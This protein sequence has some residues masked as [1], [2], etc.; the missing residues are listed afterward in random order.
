L[1]SLTR[2]HLT[3]VY[4]VIAMLGVS[5]AVLAAP[6]SGSTVTSTVLPNG[7]KVIVLEDHSADLVAVEVWVRAGNISEKK[8]NNGVAHFIEHLLFKGTVKR[9]SGQ[10]DRD[11]ESLGATLDASTTRDS[12]R[13]STV[14]ASKYFDTALD[15]IS[16][17]TMR[18]KFDPEDVQRE[19]SVILDE[20]SRRDAD[21][22]K[23]LADMMA[24]MSFPN[25]PYGFPVQGSASNVTAITVEQIREFY[26]TYF[27]PN[28]MA[29]VIVGDMKAAK[30]IEDVSAAF[31]DFKKKDLPAPQI[32]APEPAQARKEKLARGTKLTYYAIGFPAPSIREPADV[33]AMD[34]LV[35]YLA[36]GYR[37]WLESIQV[38]KGGLQMVSGEYT[39]R[40]DPSNMMLMFATDPS[41]VEQ[42]RQAI[43]NKVKALRETSLSDAEVAIAERSIEGSIAFDSETFAGR[44]HNLGFYE[45]LGDYRYA[46]SYIDEIR[47][48][49][50]DQIRRLALKYL[51]TDTCV[52]GEVGP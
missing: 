15:V 29:I 6:L 22:L 44:A 48:V 36:L 20:I 13:I 9:P 42:V 27:T 10:A 31:R 43:F 16:D 51:N 17:V 19:R 4:Y 52:I 41:N 11:I 25:H 7:L 5:T 45:A 2:V 8:S 21:P 28:N 38:P 23:T 26:Q 34:V 39:T 47:K 18:A 32:P 14:V 49:T 40:R 33:Y 37:S 3:I 12:I 50:P 24:R 35:Q 1:R 30:A 46:L